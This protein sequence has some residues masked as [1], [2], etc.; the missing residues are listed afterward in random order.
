MLLLWILPAYRH[1]PDYYSKGIPLGTMS[2]WGWH[3]APNTKGYSLSEVYRTYNVHGSKVDYV[4][5][6]T[7]KAD[8]L[9]TAATSFLRANPHRIHLGMIGLQIIKKRRFRNFIEGY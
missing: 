4:H 5:S 6:F 1:F 2:E 3:T 8:T 7:G 9:Q